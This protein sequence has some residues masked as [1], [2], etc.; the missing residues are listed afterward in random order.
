MVKVVKV[1]MLRWWGWSR[2][3]WPR[4][5]G[6]YRQGGQG[7]TIKAIKVKMGKVVEVVKLN[8]ARWSR[9]SPMVKRVTDGQEG[10][11]G[12]GRMVKVTV[13]VRWSRS[14]SMSDSQG[15]GKGPCQTVKVRFEAMV[16]SLDVDSHGHGRMVMTK[17]PSARQAERARA[18]SGKGS[19]AHDRE[20]NKESA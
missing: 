9:G 2:I 11:G 5:S 6:S 8:E 15:Q 7:Q 4:W 20:R 12:R 10:H 3:R 18:C 1:V 16:G 13:Q 14:G 19:D 17:R